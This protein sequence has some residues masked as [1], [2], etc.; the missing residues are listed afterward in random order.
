VI[1]SFDI[2]GNRVWIN[3]WQ[4]HQRV[5]NDGAENCVVQS[6][7]FLASEQVVLPGQSLERDKI[8]TNRPKRIQAEIFMGVPNTAQ[9]KKVVEIF[10][11]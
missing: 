1:S 7:N 11:E 5:L 2:F 10:G 6:P 9:Q 8:T 4:I 3:A